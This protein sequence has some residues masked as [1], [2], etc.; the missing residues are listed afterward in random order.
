[1]DQRTFCLSISKRN[2][3]YATL[4]NQYS[5]HYDLPVSETLFKIVREYH[6]A[7]QVLIEQ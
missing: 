7:K 5:Q 6:E 1:M 3:K 4:L 2:Q